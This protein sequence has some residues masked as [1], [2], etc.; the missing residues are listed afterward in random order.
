M[1]A[2][3]MWMQ[4]SRASMAAG[5][6]AASPNSAVERA[7]PGWRS[8]P[9]GRYA[10]IGWPGWP[11]GTASGIPLVTECGVSVA[12][13]GELEDERAEWLGQDDGLAAEPEPYLLPGGVDVVEGQAADR[14]GPLGVEE[15]EQVGDAVLGFDG[16]VVEQ[17]PGVVPSGLGAGDAAWPVPPGGGEVEAGQFLAPG[18]ADE[19]PGLAAMGGAVAGQPGCP[20]SRTT[21]R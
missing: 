15:Q 14:G 2:T 9:P 8:R 13:G 17:A 19:V 18:P 10:L 1:T 3:L 5:S 4:S 21:P 20:P 12:G 16:V 11:P 7:G 6:S